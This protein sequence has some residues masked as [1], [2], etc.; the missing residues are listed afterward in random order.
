MDSR[1]TLGRRTRLAR[2]TALLILGW[3]GVVYAFHAGAAWQNFRFT[4]AYLPP[5]PSWSPPV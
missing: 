3:A 1:R 4:L 5:L 2:P